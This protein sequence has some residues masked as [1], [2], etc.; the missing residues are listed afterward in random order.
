MSAR[1]RTAQL[2]A[3][4]ARLR[5]VLAEVSRTVVAAA[6]G[7]LEQRVAPVPLVP[8][9]DVA[10]LRTGLNRFIDV[11]DGFVREASAA[12]AAASQGR[13]ERRLVER[14]LPGAFRVHATSINDARA[15]MAERDTE[16]AAAKDARAG[17]A[18]AFE[19]NVL[20]A[21]GTVAA[22]AGAMTAS[23][24]EARSAEAGDAVVRLETSSAAIS[25]V[26]KLI[27]DVTSQTRLLAL[28][29]TIE[30]ARAGTAG[31]GFAVVADEVKRLAEQTREASVRV[32]EQLAESRASIT[33]VAGAL[34]E[35]AGS[36]TTMRT[37]VDDLRTGT[38]DAD[39]GLTAATGRLDAHV[40]DFLTGLREG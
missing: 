17:L 40:R 28:N 11:T 37:D 24:V 35:I 8:G 9:V 22:S 21:S 4:N 10:G 23:A 16:L 30:A 13:H 39:A 19:S 31:K 3:E 2:E 29:A 18:T 34:S 26:I 1:T 33:E 20:D 38:L 27:T 14:G 6:R 12:L 15:T 5:A 32:E 36:V 7:D 25:D